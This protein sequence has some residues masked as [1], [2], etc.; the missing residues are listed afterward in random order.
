MG[1]Y[2]EVREKYVDNMCILES[3]WLSWVLLHPLR[4]NDP[5]LKE[6]L[7]C[8]LKRICS[9]QTHCWHQILAWEPSSYT[10]GIYKNPIEHHSL[11]HTAHLAHTPSRVF[12]KGYHDSC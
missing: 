2:K 11:T 8:A 9:E 3:A 1:A 4:S 5:Y 6:T 12:T 10:L 7:F